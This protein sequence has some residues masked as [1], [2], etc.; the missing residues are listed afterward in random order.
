[1]LAL[2]LFG[3]T[4]EVV[5]DTGEPDVCADAT[6][7]SGYDV[8][9]SADPE[10][11]AGEAS[12]FTLRVRDQRG[13]PVEDLQT[14]HERVV[15]TLVIGEDLASFQHVHQEDFTALT[16]DNMRTSTFAFPLTLPTAGDYR[17][18]FDYA[19][20]NAY[21]TSVDWM[22]VGGSPTMGAAPVL[23]YGDTREVDGLIVRL[24]WDIAPY[25][26]FEASWTVTVCDPAG[27]PAAA[28]SAC[29]G[30][31]A[32]ITDVVQWLGADAHAA[33]AAADLGWVSHTHAWFPDME[34]VAPG[35]DMPHLYDG[36]QLPF[37]FTFPAAGP[38]KMWVQFAREG[39]PDVPYVADFAFDVGL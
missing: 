19:H 36:P 2:A 11:M 3:C 16:A 38:H 35:H 22:T 7:I 12:T 20:R 27:E 17:L 8:T 30:L 10:P 6:D 26:G 18:V 33:V 21:H 13:C 23:D 29:E 37:H 28:G 15:H 4:G 32:E 31:G 25:A 5:D 34:N 9:W 1:M 39:A 24:A 14:A